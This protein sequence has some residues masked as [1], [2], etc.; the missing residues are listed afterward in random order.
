M[1][2]FNVFVYREGILGWVK[3]GHRLDSLVDYPKVKIPLISS[4]E[5][6]EVNTSSTLLI[7]IRPLSHFLKGHINNSTN[8]D[9]EEL[10]RKL[11]VLPKDKKIVLIDHK[12]KL[13]LTTGRFLYS[14][15]FT[16]VSRLD[17]GFN[18][19]VKNGLPVKN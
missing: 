10:H 16:G 9:L 3:A 5:L 11:D 6:R 17:G 19:W 7:D 13:T 14:H 1:G 12:G 2:Y 8:I 18:A 4:I 15:G